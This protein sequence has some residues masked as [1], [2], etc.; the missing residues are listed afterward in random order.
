MAEEP[1]L[2]VAIFPGAQINLTI[3]ANIALRGGMPAA[4]QLDAAYAPVVYCVLPLGFMLV[5]SQLLLRLLWAHLCPSVSSICITWLVCQL[6]I[7]QIHCMLHESLLESPCFLLILTKTAAIWGPIS[8][9]HTSFI[10]M[11]TVMSSLC[12]MRPRPPRCHMDMLATTD[13]QYM[14]HF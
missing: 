5:F 4:A 12:Q 10:C 13:C 8:S 7:A 9:Q 14:P 2:K 3:K 1:I 11:S 6:H